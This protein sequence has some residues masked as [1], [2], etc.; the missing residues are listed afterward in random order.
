MEWLGWPDLVDA[1][2][3]G[4]VGDG[5]SLT[6]LLWFLAFERA[7]RGTG[8]PGEPDGPV[9]RVSPVRE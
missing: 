9:P 7:G 8:P 6:A 4:Q 3:G 2:R 5:L 1:V